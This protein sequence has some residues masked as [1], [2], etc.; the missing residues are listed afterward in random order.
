[1]IKV[2]YQGIINMSDNFVWYFGT[3]VYKLTNKE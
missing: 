3:N 1:M 2:K